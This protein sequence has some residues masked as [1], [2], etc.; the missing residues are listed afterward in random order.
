MM[1]YWTNFADANLFGFCEGG[2][3]AQDEIMCAQHPTLPSVRRALLADKDPNATPSTQTPHNCT[4]VILL[5]VP[6][7]LDVDASTIYGDRFQRASAGAI[8]SAVKAV[9]ISSKTNIIAMAAMCYMDGNVYTR[10]MI[11]TQFATAYTAFSAAKHEARG[12]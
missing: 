5:N 4:P 12:R 2:L 3:F 7:E 11:E 10:E 9:A 1:Q 8:H 6:R